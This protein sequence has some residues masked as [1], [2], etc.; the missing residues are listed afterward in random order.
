MVIQT[1]KNIVNVEC[2]GSKDFYISY[3]NDKGQKFIDKY[4]QP[5]YPYFYVLESEIIPKEMLSNIIDIKV[6]YK[7]LF[8]YK[9]KK[10]VCRELSKNVFL[11]YRDMFSKTFE[12][13]VMFLFRFIIDRDIKYSQKQKILYLDIETNFSTD[14]INVDKEII[15]LVGRDN[16]RKDKVVRFIWHADERTKVIKDEKC[17]KFDPILKKNVDYLRTT[18]YFNNEIDMLCKFLEYV[19]WVKPDIFTGYFSNLFDYPYL[20]NRMKKLGAPYQKLSPFRKVTC[21][22]ETKNDMYVKIYGASVIDLFDIYKKITYDNR[23]DNYRLSTVAKHIFND[24]KKQIKHIT[25]MWHNDREALLE[26]NEHD[27]FLTM[28]I[29][30]ASH[31]L[32]TYLTIQQIVPI[33]LHEIRHESRIIDQY[34]LRK[35]HNKIIFPSK[36]QNKKI[37]F[38]GA[39]TLQ[40][41]PYLYSHI[42]L[43]DFSGMYSNIYRTF[44]ISP[45]TIDLD[46]EIMVPIDSEAEA[47]DDRGMK[48]G[49]KIYIRKTLYFTKKKRGII[50]E[51]LD[52]LIVERQ[53]VEERRD[54]APA[55]SMERYALQNFQG[56]IKVIMNSMYGVMGYK[57][58]R[59]YN[60]DIPACITQ[61]GRNLLMHTKEIVEKNNYSIEYGDTDSVF[62]K[63]DKIYPKCTKGQVDEYNKKILVDIEN[64]KIKVNE[65]YIGFVK[66]YSL[67]N[68]TLKTDCEKIFRSIM[69]T[70]AK[71]G[72]SGLMVYERGVDTYQLFTR[73][74][75]I[76]RR[77]TPMPI[78]KVLKTI[79]IMILERAELEDIQQYI[80]N[81]IDYVQNNYSLWELGISKQISRELHTYTTNT[82][83]IRAAKYS[84][85]YFGTHFDRAD[86]PK[87]LFVKVRHGKPQTDVIMIDENIDLPD[88][89]EVDWKRYFDFFI[90][91]KLK[92]L[93]SIKNIDIKTLYTDNQSL[94]KWM[95]IK[96]TT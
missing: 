55:G 61:L 9:V 56:A 33:P 96:V 87:M 65:S 7:S 67:I 58:F 34:I 27:V 44:N 30:E 24:D 17:T 12:D 90:K 29:D 85:K 43:F 82:Q 95:K 25:D 49:Q 18:F 80:K 23:P 62:V 71:K 84:N 54:K 14:V 53:K 46:G 73:G 45:E 2:L 72:Y 39:L 76:V 78:R 50:P 94:K 70:D 3:R 32:E 64:L 51:I 60:N 19:E 42:A 16:F 40:P 75:A 5:F 77:D 89:I 35:Y 52:D 15:S 13:D 1:H 48:T 11:K 68:H 28:K 8:G 79:F 10:I 66:D 26:Y 81:Q 21:K 86:I 22:G 36:R 92:L 69:F 47:V 4:T 37:P 57:N 41:K 74:F 91:F 20:I 88:W 93:D 59:L 38:Q 63:F 6:G 83:H 31:L